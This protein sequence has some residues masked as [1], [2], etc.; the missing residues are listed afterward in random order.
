MS[1][2]RWLCHNY[3]SGGSLGI[4]IDHSDLL[5]DVQVRMQKKIKQF[6]I[7]FIIL[8]LITGMERRKPPKNIIRNS[9]SVSTTANQHE[10]SVFLQS[11]D[12]NY[13]QTKK[14]SLDERTS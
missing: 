5:H 8:Q 10:I 6:L 13:F 14:N 11:C 2:N 9:P 4:P 7:F 1:T 12:E 3:S